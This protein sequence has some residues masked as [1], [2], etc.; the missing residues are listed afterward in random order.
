MKTYLATFYTDADYAERLIRANSPEQA[1]TRARGLA[2]DPNWVPDYQSY[3]G[4]GD[5]NHIEIRSPDMTTVAEWQDDD[6]RLRLAASDMLEAL[7]LCEDAL[8]TLAR[9]DD[10]TPSI[11]ALNLTRVIIA[12]VKSPAR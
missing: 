7:E 11:S 1:L 2:S 12:K 8:S 5:I 6:L 10:G 9:L 3:D 4:P